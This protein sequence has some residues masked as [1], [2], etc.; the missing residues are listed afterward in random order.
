VTLRAGDTN[1]PTHLSREIF[2]ETPAKFSQTILRLLKFRGNAPPGPINVVV[3][4]RDER[5]IGKTFHRQQVADLSGEIARPKNSSE[6]ILPLP[7]MIDER[8]DACAFNC[9]KWSELLE[10]FRNALN[11]CW[12]RVSVEKPVI[13]AASAGAPKRAPDR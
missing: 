12:R 8:A 1:Q 2:P 3:S 10:S 7:F 5:Q 13:A 9:N 11:P 6:K 4:D